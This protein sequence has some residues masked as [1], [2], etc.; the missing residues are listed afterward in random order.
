MSIGIVPSMPRGAELTSFEIAI[1]FVGATLP[2]TRI[3]FWYND[4]CGIFIADTTFTV[5][6]L[7][8][9]L[10]QPRTV[11]PITARLTPAAV[12]VTIT[13]PAGEQLV[14]RSLH[15]GS[16]TGTTNMNIGGREYDYAMYV[17]NLTLA[18]ALVVGEQGIGA[19]QV[20][21]GPAGTGMRQIRHY[22]LA[23][24]LPA[25]A[26]NTKVTTTA[27]TAVG[28]SSSDLLFL[29]GMTGSA[30]PVNL[31]N[32]G[33]VAGTDQ[34]FMNLVNF[35]ATPYVGGDLFAFTVMAISL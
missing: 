12:F 15:A 7:T 14:L 25:V 2:N 13:P 31:I 19:G 9:I 3:Q 16:S 34:I 6:M 20:T 1:A 22:P 4:G 32:A 29:S 10:T 24:N 21:I 17:N 5:P 27:F 35:S 28:V 30:L 11:I 33:L 18:T 26:A 23:G 8:D